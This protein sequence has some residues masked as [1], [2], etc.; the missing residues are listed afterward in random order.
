M[1]LQTDGRNKVK[2]KCRVK[3]T[4]SRVRTEEELKAIKEIVTLLQRGHVKLSWTYSENGYP[5]RQVDS[6][7]NTSLR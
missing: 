1:D 7:C 6:S 4:R 2:N 3:R 5:R